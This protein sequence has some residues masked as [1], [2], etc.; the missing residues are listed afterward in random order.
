MSYSF[1][2]KA[3]PR[4]IVVLTA[5][6]LLNASQFAVALEFGEPAKVTNSNSSGGLAVRVTAGSTA[7]LL[8]RI[9]D[10]TVVKL[11]E[12]PVYR[13]SMNWWKH[14]E[15]GWSAESSGGTVYLAKL[16]T[17][18]NRPS[19][20][21]YAKKY[22]LNRNTAWDDYSNYGGDCTNFASQ[23]LNAGG[24][25]QDKGGSY[26]W[27]YTSS[28]DRAPAWTKSS[29]L[30]DYILGNTNGIGYNGPQGRAIQKSQLSPG[31]LI[32]LDQRGLGF[33][34]T[35][36]VVELTSTDVIVAYRNSAGNDPR[37][38]KKLSEIKFNSIAYIRILGYRRTGS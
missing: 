33:E 16:L 26:L 28:K 35:M 36:I 17:P 15:G 29:E 34:H 25:P 1:K 20:V 9:P 31:D 24:I 10:G 11:L 14:S 2:L 12:G 8:K 3:L 27:Y 4:A 37:V 6:V 30:L 19:A 22:A 21:A 18:Y 7:K 23:V 13:N 5:M 38:D 32:F